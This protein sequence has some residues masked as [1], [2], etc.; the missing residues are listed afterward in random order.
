MNLLQLLNSLGHIES[1]CKR[2]GVRSERW[3]DTKSPEVPYCIRWLV[4]ARS[5]L[6]LI[7]VWRVDRDA[8]RCVRDSPICGDAGPLKGAGVTTEAPVNSAA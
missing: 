6:C 5:R 7:S 4:S 1:E 8:T 3:K 2:A